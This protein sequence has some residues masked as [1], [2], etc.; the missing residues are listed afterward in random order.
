MKITIAKLL[1]ACHAANYVHHPKGVMIWRTGGVWNLRII[2]DD[3]ETATSCTPD[4]SSNSAELAVDNL[5]KKLAADLERQAE[6]HHADS[7][8]SRRAL[9]EISGVND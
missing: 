1:E 5:C 6:R 7:L 9:Q 8:A 3:K 2:R 4:A